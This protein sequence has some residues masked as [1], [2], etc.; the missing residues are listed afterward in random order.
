VLFSLLPRGLF[1]WKSHWNSCSFA[2]FSL[3]PRR[4]FVCKSYQ[5]SCSFDILTHVYS[6]RLRNTSFSSL[7][8]VVIEAEFFL[9]FVEFSQIRRTF[10]QLWPFGLCTASLRDYRFVPDRSFIQH[11]GPARFLCKSTW[12]FHSGKGSENAVFCTKDS[13]NFLQEIWDSCDFACARLSVFSPTTFEIWSERE[14]YDRHSF[15]MACSAPSIGL[16]LSPSIG[17]G[18]R[19]LPSSSSSESTSAFTPSSQQQH[20]NI[21]SCF[22]T[23][24]NKLRLS[25]VEGFQQVWIL[26]TPPYMSETWK[27]NL[28]LCFEDS[29]VQARGIGLFDSLNHLEQEID[30]ST[31]V[32]RKKEV[33]C[34]EHG[35]HKRM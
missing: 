9:R 18:G 35:K 27:P 12:R 16:L 32:S 33:I 24:S 17:V 5:N 13:R 25:T 7:F 19:T 34:M 21:S 15:A 2:L 31:Q 22:L 4:L 6:D 8:S 26:E 30:Q 11:C 1:V 23:T 20:Y 14:R 10:V 29:L 28:L 3:L